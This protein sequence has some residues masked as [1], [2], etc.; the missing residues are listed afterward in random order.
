MEKTTKL[1]QHQMKTSRAVLL[2]ICEAKNVSHWEAAYVGDS[3]TRNVLWGRLPVYSLEQRITRLLGWRWEVGSRNLPSIPI[4]WKK[5]KRSLAITPHNPFYR[6]LIASR[7]V[8][9][10]APLVCLAAITQWA[11]S[12]RYA[13]SLSPM[14]S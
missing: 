9:D 2:A 1:S 7:S 10:R 3:I 8:C 6:A 4:P 14:S 5:S 12:G 13:V 11:A